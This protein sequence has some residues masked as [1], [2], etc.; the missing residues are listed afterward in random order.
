MPADFSPSLDLQDK[1]DYYQL[2]EERSYQLHDENIYLRAK[3]IGLEQAYNSGR[4]TIK[5]L[6]KEIEELKKA[7]A[8]LQNPRKHWINGIKYK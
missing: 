1:T 7:G 8:A 6:R 3:V 5:K 2:L 4:K